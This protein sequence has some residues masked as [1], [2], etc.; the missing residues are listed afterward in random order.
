MG[1]FLLLLAV[2][3]VVGAIVFGVAALITGEDPG[4]GAEEPDGRAVPLPAARPLV[5]Q[6]IGGLRFDTALRG[7]RMSQ[8]DAALR[9]AAYDL[10]YKDELIGVLESEIAALREGRVEDADALRRSRELAIGNA[11]QDAALDDAAHDDA[12]PDDVAPDDAAADDGGGS[13]GDAPETTP[14]ASVGAQP[15]DPGRSTD[16]TAPTAGP[17]PAESAGRG[18]AAE[19]P[20]VGERTTGVR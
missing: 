14:P 17:V 1:Q 10:G 9:R 19:E 3:L 15:T 2:A 7:Y 12:A 11:A 6:D 20:Q 4:L 5:E 8:V 13:T 18:G 16:P